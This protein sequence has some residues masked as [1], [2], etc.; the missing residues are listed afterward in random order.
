MA[1]AYTNILLEPIAGVTRIL[2]RPR[3]GRAIWGEAPPVS[4]LS[5]QEML[6]PILGTGAHARA[7]PDRGPQDRPTLS[8]LLWANTPMGSLNSPSH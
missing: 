2:T 4:S 7:S 6:M 3:A 5:Q 8:L 1:Q